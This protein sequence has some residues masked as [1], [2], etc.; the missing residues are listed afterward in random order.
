MKKELLNRF[1]SL[2][3]QAKRESFIEINIMHKEPKP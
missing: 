3:E 2:N 1:F